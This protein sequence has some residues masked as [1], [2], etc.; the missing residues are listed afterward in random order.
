MQACSACSAYMQIYHTVDMTLAF[1]A[2]GLQVW[3]WRPCLAYRSAILCHPEHTAS[4]LPCSGLQR[5][6][7]RPILP[8]SPMHPTNSPWQPVPAG[9]TSYHRM[10]RLSWS[11]WRQGGKCYQGCSSHAKP[12]P[13]TVGEQQPSTTQCR[14]TVEVEN[15]NI[16]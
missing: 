13:C 8:T 7:L 11:G 15:M 10:H 4:L 14:L 16:H 3:E 12:W 2:P 5:T 6:L 1:G 9:S